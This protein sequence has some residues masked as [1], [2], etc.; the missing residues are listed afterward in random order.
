MLTIGLTGGIGCGKTATT[1]LFQ[2]KGVPVIDADQIAH[3]IVQPKQAALSIII[4][5]FGSHFLSSSGSLN[6]AKL[7]QY[8]FENP[9]E[10]KKLENILHPIIFNTMHEQ[11]A[12]QKSPY[13][14]LSV[15][16]LFETR[17]QD[18]VDRVLVIDCSEHTQRLRVKNRDNIN[19]SDIDKIINSQCS[20][21]YRLENANDIIDNSDSLNHLKKE[22]NKLHSLYIK[23][24]T[25]NNSSN[26]SK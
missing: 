1:I 8:I 6:R 18:Q 4:D 21:E 5:Q 13:G 2:Q 15:P 16:L 14:I 19:E 23:I 10:K 24:S 9:D 22:I 7:R 11:L 20:R 3:Q 25:G 17:Y 26:P 12:R